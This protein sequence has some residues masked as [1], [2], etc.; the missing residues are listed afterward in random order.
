MARKL[1]SYVHLVE[2]DSQAAVRFGPGDALPEWAEG[3][4]TNPAAWAADAEPGPMGVDASQRASSTQPLTPV[5]DVPEGTVE[6]VLEWVMAPA[7]DEQV[8]AR[9]MAALTVEM[10][11]DGRQRSGITKPLQA[12]TES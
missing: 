11:P 7:E 5:D 8:K 2:P 6:D 3:L 4:I 10:G 12:L 1:A 9:A